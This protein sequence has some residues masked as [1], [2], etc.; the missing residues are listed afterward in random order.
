MDLAR[1]SPPKLATE[2]QEAEKQ[3]KDGLIAG[4]KIENGELLAENEKLNLQH[5][6]ADALIGKLQLKIQRLLKEMEHGNVARMKLTLLVEQLEQ[7]AYKDE[8]FDV[9]NRKGFINT[10]HAVRELLKRESSTEQ[11][12]NCVLMMIDIDKF[13]S[14]NDTFGHSIGDKVI[15]VLI[16]ELKRITRNSDV[17]GRFGGDEVLVFFPTAEV[18][19]IYRKFGSDENGFAGIRISFQPKGFEK[20]IEFT[21]SGG[22]VSVAPDDNLDD[23]LI[24]ADAALYRA[25]D[26]RRNQILEAI[27]ADEAAVSKQI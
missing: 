24:V 25:K 26:S 12:P 6:A 14:I 4:L 13:K 11:K 8:T 18:D 23:R 1:S 3:G 22:L 27:E 15:E 20:P 7:N 16:N 2:G 10:V 9:L 5:S 19:E 21:V 17:I